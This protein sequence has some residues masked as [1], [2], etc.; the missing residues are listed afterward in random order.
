MPKFTVAKSAHINASPERVFEFVSDFGTW[1][2]W[3]PW[4]AAQSDPS[5]V[6]SENS[7]SVGSQYSWEGDVVGKGSIQHMELVPG[8]SIEDKL[9]IL[10]PWKSQSDVRFDFVGSD[11]GTEITW[12]MNGSLPLMLFWMKSMMVNMIGMDYARGLKMLG[13]LIETGSIQSQTK[14]RGIE[15]VGP[16]HMVGVRTNAKMD[17]ID[18]VMEAAL[19]E[20]SSK[21]TDVCLAEEGAGISVYH[22]MN[23]KTCVLDFTSGFLVQDPNISVPGLSLWSLPECKAFTVEHVGKYEHL[24]NPWNAAYQN[25]RYKKLKQNKKAGT[26]EIYRNDPKETDPKDLVTEVFLPLK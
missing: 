4:L 3:S 15:T 17:D 22:D 11:E 7:N 2:K 1:T 24:G 9:Q 13:E 20:V 19:T 16:L 18:K 8:K 12:T 26:F 21:L 14:I 5:V 25:V 6:V 10:K 23:M